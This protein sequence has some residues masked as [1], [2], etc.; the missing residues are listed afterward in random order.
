MST[1]LRCH[2]GP[3]QVTEQHARPSRREDGQAVS[4]LRRREVTGPGFGQSGYALANRVTQE[5]DS[6]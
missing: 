1:E 4:Q 2:D 3:D 6:A 5:R